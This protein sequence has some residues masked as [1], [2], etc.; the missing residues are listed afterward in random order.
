MGYS[1]TY[2]QM[3]DDELL[4]VAT[5][6]ASLEENA[7][8]A[9]TVELT[10]RKL[11][12][13]DVSGY[14]E[15]VASFKPED[16]WGKD[17]HIARSFNGFGTI[18]YGKRDFEADGSFVT[19]KWVVMFFIPLFPLASMRVKAV[20]SDWL[21]NDY[22][23]R[24]RGWPNLKQVACVY[25]YV[26]LLLLMAWWA[27]LLPGVATAPILGIILPLPWLLRK[28]ARGTLRTGAGAAGRSAGRDKP[29]H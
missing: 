1:E 24:E 16:F 15:R 4:N 3:S 9:I 19:T 28:S 14:R 23:V 22:L 10:R 12:E 6:F 13:T 27:D 8:M 21:M 2:G 11:S 20:K 17:E 26:G 25:A 29:E 7:R 5:D 18:L